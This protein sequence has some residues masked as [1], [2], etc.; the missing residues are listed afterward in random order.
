LYA[1]QYIELAQRNAVARLLDTVMKQG[2]IDSQA[3]S[4]LGNGGAPSPAVREAV[5][6]IVKAIGEGSFS[7]YKEQVSE[8]DSLGGSAPTP[9]DQEAIAALKG[10]YYYSW[11]DYVLANEVI[12]GSAGAGDLGQLRVAAAHLDRMTNQYAWSKLG[13]LQG[14]ADPLAAETRRF[15]AMN[16]HSE[17]M[18]EAAIARMVQDSNPESKGVVAAALRDPEPQVRMQA[19]QTLSSLDSAA[20]LAAATPLYTT[21]PN[22]DMRSVALAVI[23]A[24]RGKAALPTLLEAVSPDRT[25]NMRFTAM[26]FLAHIRDPQSEDALERTT[27]TVEDRN[28]RQV[29]LQSLAATGDSARATALALRLIGDYDPLF[30]VTAVQVVGQVGGEA[31]KAKLRDAMKKETR[32]FVRL[33]MKNAL[34]PPAGMGH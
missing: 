25:A 1:S 11:A 22:D 6:K 30:A 31:G 20:G 9:S 4:A 18:R 19:L 34:N 17:W 5:D 2:G 12:G 23:A 7:G 3:V 16:D 24:V 32:V 33:A 29:A 8:L 21:D 14:K 15:L 28:I 10:D 26:N 13:E 27:A